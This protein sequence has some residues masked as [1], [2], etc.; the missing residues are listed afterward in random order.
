MSINANK[1]TVRRLYDEFWNAE[2]LEVADELLHPDYVFDEAI[3][4]QS[5]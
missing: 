2:K 5:H 3:P 1:A 4:F